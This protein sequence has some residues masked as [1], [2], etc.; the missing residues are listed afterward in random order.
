M[1]SRCDRHKNA[2]HRDVCNNVKFLML[3]VRDCPGTTATFDVCPFPW[4]RKVKHSLYHLVSCIRPKTCAICSPKG[5]S[6][7]LSALVGLNNHRRM[8]QRERRAAAVAAA[9][10]AAR[11]KAPTMARPMKP[12][13]GPPVS[14]KYAY[15]P[16]P[17]KLAPPK[18]GPA[19]TLARKG[20]T[21][22]AKPT[23]PPYP[24]S[25]KLPSI[26]IASQQPVA[27]PKGAVTSNIPG[28][29]KPAAVPQVKPA[30]TPA[31]VAQEST[32][33][34]LAGTAST[35]PH[36]DGTPAEPLITTKPAVS[37]MSGAVGQGPTVPA[38]SPEVV[39]T[40]ALKPP[41]ANKADAETVAKE[42]VTAAAVA[43]SD[44][45]GA[46]VPPCE[47]VTVI[48]TDSMHEKCTGG[49]V[50]AC[51]PSVLVDDKKI[52]SGAENKVVVPQAVALPSMQEGANSPL[53]ESSALSSS[54]ASRSSSAIAAQSKEINAE[55]SLDMAVATPAAA[56]IQESS[57]GSL[58]KKDDSGNEHS[59]E[60]CADE[61]CNENAKGD[62]QEGSGDGHSID[63]AERKSQ[64]TP[65]PKSPD[66]PEISSSCSDEV[67][68]KPEIVRISSC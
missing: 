13:V 32:T 19:S 43:V 51:E 58:P 24:A 33:S 63:L 54:K 45:E 39:A 38:T 30:S 36:T 67:K 50:E 11:G 5:L 48:E 26:E 68:K 64:G 46:V 7:N 10:A 8:K 15:K 40:G 42:G 53:I 1:I 31:A 60:N 34:R 29:K 6:P 59:D 56:L 17:P 3:H 25:R 65:P 49:T 9:A 66:S 14:S 23:I 47:A 37:S 62:L 22:M 55:S 12:G 16:A 41:V 52:S 2:K 21:P 4:C 28:G 57:S 18:P 61:C 20:V 35:F 44:K 27:V